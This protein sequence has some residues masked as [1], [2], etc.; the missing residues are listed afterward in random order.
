M[1]EERDAKIYRLWHEEKMTFA[2]IGR[3]YGL[4][5]ERVRQICMREHEKRV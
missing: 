4:S 5:R 1:E 3:R 2:G